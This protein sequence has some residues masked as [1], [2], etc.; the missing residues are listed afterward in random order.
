M[1]TH[2]EYVKNI[3]RIKNQIQELDDNH[4]IQENW[5]DPV[6]TEEYEAARKLLVDELEAAYKA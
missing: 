5:M 3:Y 2:N 6:A 4:Y 1:M